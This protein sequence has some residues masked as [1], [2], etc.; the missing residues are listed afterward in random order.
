MAA[1]CKFSS[2]NWQGLLE[3]DSITNFVIFP[4]SREDEV[5]HE[6]PLNILAALHRQRDKYAK[7]IDFTDSDFL[8]HWMT[9]FALLTRRVRTMC[10]APEVNEGIGASV[11]VTTSPALSII[12]AA[13]AVIAAHLH[14][15]DPRLLD[16]F[17]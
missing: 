8:W 2:I 12:V 10:P 17:R 15:D 11:I 6:M 7:E 13:S 4:S 3:T 16:P 5:T 1:C 14:M 9:S